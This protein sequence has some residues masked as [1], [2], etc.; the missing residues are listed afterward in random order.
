MLRGHAIR[1]AVHASSRACI[2]VSCVG[3]AGCAKSCKEDRPYVPYA[4]D[5]AAPVAGSSSTI[6][7]PAPSGSGPSFAVVRAERAQGA[8]VLTIDGSVLAAPRGKLLHW[9]LKAD[10][11]GDGKD[12]VAAWALDEAGTQGELAWYQRQDKG[13]APA[14]TLATAPPAWTVP[15]GCRIEAELSRVGPRTA[16]LLLQTA[17][18]DAGASTTRPRW[19]AVI[20]PARQPAV[21]VDAIV[22][23]AL[24]GEDL[25][26]Q[27]DGSDRDGDGIDDV[28]LV[29]SLSGEPAPLEAQGPAVSAELRWFD[30]P[31]GL[32]RDPHEPDASLRG[33]ASRLSKVARKKGALAEVQSSV[34]RLHR[35]QAI[36]CGGAT[37]LQVQ[38]APVPCGGSL[39]L[40]EAE[41]AELEA[42]IKAADPAAAVAAIDRMER[43]SA[44][45]DPKRLADAR[46]HFEKGFGVAEAQVRDAP[47]A[48]MTGPAGVPAWGALAFEPSGALLVRENAGIVRID[49]ATLAASPA[50]AGSPAHASWMVPLA[51]PAGS[52]ML[53]AVVDGCDGTP[54]RARMHASD[55]TSREVP[56]PIASDPSSFC[57]GSKVIPAAVPLGWNGQG[58]EALIAGSVVRIS[59]DPPKASLAT[60]AGMGPIPPG[61]ARSPDGRWAAAPLGWGVAVLG[62]NG[63]ATLW[64][65]SRLQDAARKLR[66]CTVA[67]DAS[68]AACVEGSRVIWIAPERNKDGG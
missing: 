66:D 57:G 33:H 64:K 52:W 12:D 11:N 21:R 51:A 54:L 40:Q 59:A 49:P 28:A 48:P 44:Q 30:R 13:F 15:E 24:A 35:L 68:A 20:S 5:A 29:V 67:N 56:L 32:S 6:A 31:A 26:V 58:L 9:Y 2:L 43:P 45:F 63:K 16:F 62:P 42:A 7:P 14:A 36:L 18:A 41:L 1:R 10:W 60:A 46:A 17:C 27:A 47:G 53:E 34:R 19:A 61:A 50:P 23:P 37:P 22:P 65:S 39:G 3:L 55:G 38:G 25:G 4:I 8:A